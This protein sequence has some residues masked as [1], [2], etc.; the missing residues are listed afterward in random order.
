MI[1]IAIANRKGGVGKSTVTANIAAALGMKG[2]RV[3]VIDMD[4]QG[5]ASATLLSELAE[6]AP[7]TAHV[8]GGYVDDIAKIIVPSSSKN[9]WIVPASKDLTGATIGIVAKNG[10][11]S[12]LRRALKKVVDY[13]FTLIDTAPEAAL[14]T[15]NAFVAANYVLMPF[16]PDAKALEGLSTTSEAVNDIVQAELSATRILGCVQVVYDK[17]LAVTKESREQVSEVFKSLLFDSVIRTNAN[18][19]LTTAWHKDIFQLE[20]EQ[21]LQKKGSDDFRGLAEEFLKVV[22][23]AESEKLAA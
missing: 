9:V 12:I 16:T 21:K 17:R 1:T 23:K 22:A 14:A 8:I 4:S 10:R 11:E 20:T 13:D 7:T 18:F 5:S 3:L 19:L 6:D 2:K 15:A